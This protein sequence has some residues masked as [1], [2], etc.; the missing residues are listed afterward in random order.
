[1]RVISY[2]FMSFIIG[3]VWWQI[4]DE[5]DAGDVQDMNGVTYFIAEFFVVM[6]ISV[7]P[8]QIED[9][10]IMVKEK[11]NGSYKLGAFS[12]S[13]FVVSIPFAFIV[14]VLPGIIVY[15]MVGF[16]EEEA[17]MFIFNLF[18]CVV[19]SEAL[20]LIV[21]SIF[22]HLLICIVLVALIIGNLNK[23][24]IIIISYINSF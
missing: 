16:K 11:T 21:A 7:L 23:K 15:Y 19:A 5:P 12:F 1:M 8:N 10:L 24:S 13:Q 2:C 14:S 3:T 4:A 9:R 6:T 22:S 17:A 18:L 20:M